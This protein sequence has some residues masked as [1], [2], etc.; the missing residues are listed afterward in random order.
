MT[1]LSDVDIEAALRADE[2]LCISHFNPDQIQP[3]SYDVTLSVAGLT[4]E[5]LR[6][7]EFMLASTNEVFVIPSWLAARVEGKSSWGRRGLLVHATAGFI[8]PGFRGDITLELANIGREPLRLVPGMAISQVSFHEL[9]T[10]ARRPYGSPGLGSHYQGQ[11][12]PTP[13][14]H[15]SFQSDGT[16]EPAIPI[17]GAKLE[18]GRGQ[19]DLLDHPDNWRRLKAQ[20]AASG[21]WA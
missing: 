8:D 7:G 10:P 21:E 15:G 19:H 3:A 11:R 1:I 6:P 16:P 2:P 20:K 12:G 4:S 9:S 13:S 5:W 18:Q 17:R 14:W